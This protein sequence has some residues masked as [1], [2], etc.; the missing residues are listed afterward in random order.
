MKYSRLFLVCLAVLALVLCFRLAKPTEEVRLVATSG[1]ISQKSETP[2]TPVLLADDIPSAHLHGQKTAEWPGFEGIVRAGELLENHVSRFER[3]FWEPVLEKAFSLPSGVTLVRRSAI[4]RVPDFPFGLVR[5][6]RVYRS[7]QA[8]KVG[9]GQEQPTAKPLWENAM[10]ADHLMVKAKPGRTETALKLALPKGC[11]LRR[12]LPAC[13][14]LYLVE[15]PRSGLAALEKA[16]T[17]LEEQTDLVEY[18]EP[19]FVTQGA[20]TAPNDPGYAGTPGPQWHLP[21]ILAPVAWD[22]IKEPRTPT[23]AAGIVVAVMDTGV[24]YTHPDLAANIWS[25]PNDLPGN[26]DDDE[27][28]L[29]DDIRGWD[30]IDNDNNP[31]DDVGHGTHVAGIIG[32]IGNNGLGVTGL[33]WQVKIL[34]VRIIRKTPA[35]TFGT[36]SAAVPAMNYIKQL[37]QNER[38]V[39]VANHS[40]GGAGYSKSMLEAINNPVATSDPRPAGLKGTSAP[41]PKGAPAG[42]KVNEILLVGTPGE[43]PKIRS[44]MTI[45]GPGI[46]VGTL[47]TIV[48][49]DRIFLSNFPSTPLRSGALTFSNPVRPKPYGIIHVAAAGNKGTNNDLIPTYPS[50]T[51]S[52]F[53]LSVGASDSA[54][55]RSVWPGAGASNFGAQTVDIFSPGTG[56][57]SLK[58]KASGDPGY[59]YESRDGTSMAAP[60]VAGTAALLTMWQPDVRDPRHIRQ[61]ILDNTDPVPSLAGQCASGGRLNVARILDKLYQPLLVDSGGSTGGGTGTGASPLSI[62]LSLSGQVAKGDAFTLAVKEGQVWAWGWGFYGQV[63]GA[64]TATTQGYAR[65]SPIAIPGSDDAVMVAATGNTAFMLKGDGTVWAWGGNSDGLLATGSTDVLAHPSPIQ[66]TGLWPVGNPQPRA[67]WISAGGLPGSSHVTVVNADGSVWAWGRNGRGQLGDGTQTDRFTPVPVTGLTDVA[68]T[69]VGSRYTLAMKQDGTVWQWGQRLALPDTSTPNLVPAQTPGISTA[70]YIAA[71]LNTAYVVL[72]D[73]SVKWWGIFDGDADTQSGYPASTVTPLAYTELTDMVAITAGNGFALGVDGLGRVFSWGRNDLGQ[74]GT[75]IPFSASRP[76]EIASL[77]TDGVGA[78]AAGRESS[79][80]L[81]SNGEVMAWGRNQRGELGT[82]RLDESLLPVQVPGISGIS[83][84]RAG[85]APAAAARRFDGSWLA[86]GFT[87]AGPLSQMPA[88]FTEASGFTDLKTSWNRDFVLAARAN[89]TLVAWGQDNEWGEFGNNTLGIPGGTD[90]PGPA[91]PVA[92][93]NVAGVLSFAV[94][95]GANANPPGSGEPYQASLHCLAVNADGTVRAWGRNHLG[96][97]G[98]GSTTTRP[99]PV[100]VSGLT[101]V[102]AVSAGGAHSLALKN[103]GSVWAWGANFFSQLGDGTVANRATPVRVSALTEIIQI[104]AGREANAALKADGSVWV[105][106]LG[107]GITSAVTAGVA[108]SIPVQVPGLPPLRRIEVGSD[109]VMGIDA[110]GDVWAWSLY[111]GLLGRFSSSTL[112]PWTPARV[113]GI[114]QITD[115]SVGEGSALAVRADGSLWVWGNGES[116]FL[117]DGSAWSITPQFVIGFG[118]TSDTLSGLGSGESA[119]SWQLQRFS[120]EDLRDPEISD[121]TADPDDDRLA[122]LLEFALGLDPL[123]KDVVGIPVPV[124]DI[125]SADVSLESRGQIELFATGELE[126]NK[127]YFGLSVPR[128]GIRRDVEYIVE[129]STDLVTW[130]SGDPN[131]VT[132]TDNAEQLLVYSTEPF[133]NTPNEPAQFIRLRVQRQDGSVSVTSPAYA[134]DLNIVKQA[135][136]ALGA[137]IVTEGDGTVNVKVVMNPPPTTALT[138]PLI[139]GGTALNGL[140]KDYTTGAASVVFVAGEKE[141]NIPISLIQDSVV[142]PVKELTITL[143]RPTGAAVSLALG[144]PSRHVLTLIDDETKPRITGQPQTQLIPRGTSFTVSSGSTASPAPLM[145]WLL[146]GKAVGG[147][148]SGT[149]SVAKAEAANA[150][151][152]VLSAQNVLGTVLSESAA[153][154]IVDTTAKTL[155][156]KPGSTTTL[157]IVTGGPGL[158]HRWHKDNSPIN[159]VGIYSG[160]GTNA[161]KLTNMA[162][163]DSGRYHCVVTM[164][165]LTLPSGVQTVRVMNLPP[166]IITPVVIPRRVVIGSS[167]GPVPLP[168]NSALNRGVVTYSAKN[169]PPGIIID[170]KTGVLSGRPTKLQTAAF[171]VVF[172]AK[173]IVNTGTGSASI[174]VLPLPDNLAGNYE[175]YVERDPSVNSSLGGRLSLTVTSLGTYTG[176]LIHGTTSIPLKGSLDTLPDSLTSSS[177]L[178]LAPR[179]LPALALEFTIDTQTQKLTNSRVTVGSASAAVRGWRQRIANLSGYTGYYTLALTQPTAPA[180][181]P[182][183]AGYASFT[184]DAKGLLK[185]AGKLA[186]GVALTSASFVGV[187]GQVLLHQ[188]IAATDTILGEL[189]ITPGTSVGG[190]L[191]WSRALQKPAER[192]YQR[193]F[194]ALD[195]TCFGGPYTEPLPAATSR[196]MGLGA[197]TN[198]ARLSFDYADFG[199]PVKKPDNLVTILPKSAVQLPTFADATR[200]FTLTVTP[201]TGFFKGDATLIDPNPTAAGNVT[202]KSTFEGMIVRQTNGLLRGHGFFVLDDLPV[203]LP[204]KTTPTTSPKTAGRVWFNHAGDTLATDGQSTA[205]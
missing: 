112:D 105:W 23:E 26:G 4:Y 20:A 19:D 81:L 166:E 178:T 85:R 69:S 190:N 203:L 143:N 21:K 161:L 144:L 127:R 77:G 74:L 149:Y 92:V 47:V 201:K 194:A 68:M 184:V 83:L 52:G 37:N 22:V 86:W 117:G 145:Q 30:F 66:V 170:P 147:A 36:Y 61:L 171:N 88:A 155:D 198:N 174:T 183:G 152:Y 169:L 122:N 142:E 129:V 182:R 135:S 153:I 134:T 187:D 29:I 167:Y 148:K 159:D 42:T 172:S 75:G 189:L 130:K 204:V 133:D 173:N 197:G 146:N 137:S 154:G 196:V 59:G 58:W 70:S 27:N 110:Q 79:I 165:A 62:G 121:D 49:G 5:V 15:V 96:Q 12:R 107:G 102:I 123:T 106:G 114:S 163:T 51:P 126:A 140:K 9:S 57:W 34:P 65:S 125:I 193:G 151:T 179:G 3:T 119:N 205:P 200:K 41:V 14:D 160:T 180:S 18:A 118:G 191:T 67:V 99:R 39:A 90:P 80:V 78:I 32:A 28:K 8:P 82:G 2:A 164:G 43:F 11:Q 139:F 176:T 56:I 113:E 72:E 35:G 16:V 71:G 141:K 186:D 6:D 162:A 115:L 63:P 17:L 53:I 54:D 45:T 38:Q 199:N 73:G 60:L 91:N 7:D 177:R 13:D 97:L 120:A 94:S 101:G 175:G 157:T 150:G 124:L 158:V 40:W 104:R 95:P 100:T 136:F 156:F 55:A 25:N 131:T 31:M 103:D 202:R 108:V 10:I 116:G 46:P 76:E 89:G 98:D 188:A 93:Q 195:V 132:L 33:C 87:G 24:D 44:G 185:I 181:R 64:E 109:A 48:R 1:G 111:P 50:S 192:L 84:A 168:V 128:Q 138:L